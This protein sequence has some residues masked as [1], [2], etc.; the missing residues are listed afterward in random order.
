MGLGQ[1]VHLKGFAR[2]NLLRIG[3]LQIACPDLA[4]QV[5]K[6]RKALY[7]TG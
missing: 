3:D 7:Y 2:D 4:S 6:S 5:I 1:I